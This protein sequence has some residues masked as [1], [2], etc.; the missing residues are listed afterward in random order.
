LVDIYLG[1]RHDTP[2]PHDGHITFHIHVRPV[3][4]FGAI[5][6]HGVGLAAGDNGIG[7]RIVD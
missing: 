6:D 5:L 2:A 4:L 7:D 3:R 1:Y